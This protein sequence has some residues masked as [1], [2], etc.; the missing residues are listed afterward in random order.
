MAQFVLKDADIYAGPVELSCVANNVTIDTTAD[1]LDATTFCSD[2]W[3]TMVGGM[4]TWSLQVAGFTN[5]AF[6]SATPGYDQSTDLALFDGIGVAG[7]ITI[8]P[9]GPSSSPVYFGTAHNLSYSNGAG[10]GELMSFSLNASGSNY[11]GLMRGQF[12]AD[13]AERTGTGT[14]TAYDHGSALTSTKRVYV[15]LH[16]LNSTLT[17]GDTITIVSDDNS[18]FT[19]G[20]T[21][22]TWDAQDA[23][24]KAIQSV[25]GVTDRYWRVEYDLSEPTTFLVVFAIVG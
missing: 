21:R 18:G 25:T 20:T 13:K 2:G 8:A 3:K 7:P 10:V 9:Q 22:L 23:D 14:V 6:E 16:Q 12:L 5:Y 15:A 11:A 19:S 24:V 1:E 17:P 4:K